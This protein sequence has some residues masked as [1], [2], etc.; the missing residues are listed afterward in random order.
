MLTSV[1]TFVSDRQKGLVKAAG[2]VG[3]LYLVRQ[4]I[5]DRLDEVKEKLEE[6]R[7]ARDKCVYCLHPTSCKNLCVVFSAA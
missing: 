3:G 6:E 4:Y 5:R 1:R 2:V 7:V